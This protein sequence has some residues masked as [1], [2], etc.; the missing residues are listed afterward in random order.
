M[1]ETKRRGFYEMRAEAR[2][3]FDSLPLPDGLVW[4]ADMTS[5]E[6]QGGNL[7]ALQMRIKRAVSGKFLLWYVNYNLDGRN[8]DIT[9]LPPPAIRWRQGGAFTNF[10]EAPDDLRDAAQLLY[11]L[12]VIGGVNS[13]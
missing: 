6:T 7:S 4:D 13:D 12:V 3:I 2:K 1:S 9:N 10:C 11:Q 8:V 5:V